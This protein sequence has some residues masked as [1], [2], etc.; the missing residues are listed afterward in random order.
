MYFRDTSTRVETLPKGQNKYVFSVVTQPSSTVAGLTLTEGVVPTESSWTMTQVEVSLVEIGRFVRFSN[1][2]LS[3]SPVPTIANATKTISKDV[4]KVADMYIQDQIDGGTN[5]IYSG[6]A[7]AR[8]NIDASDTL[9]ADDLAKAAALLRANNAET[10]ESGRYVGISHPL[11]LKD[12]RADTATGGWLDSNK[13][14]TPEKIFNG[15]V[16]AI[17]G[18]RV[19]ESGNVQFYADAGAS[20][21]VDVYPTFVFGQNSY[22]VVM[23]GEPEVRVNGLGSAGTNDPLAQQASVGVKTRLGAALLRDAAFYRI[24][25]AASLGANT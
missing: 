20:S 10:F 19:I 5:V 25:S 22:G 17:N 2:V 21:T 8:N 13:Y 4:A 3:D 14:V 7:T 11:T 15:E 12:L 23:G 24:E 9:D 6:N 16:G 1:I 18:V